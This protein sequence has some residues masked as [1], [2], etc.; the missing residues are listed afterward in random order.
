MLDQ[1]LASFVFI[2]P[3]ACLPQLPMTSKIVG[4]QPARAIPWLASIQQY[5]EHFCGGLL[6]G[7]K[8]LLTAAHCAKIVVPSIRIVVG[9]SRL[10]IEPTI[11]FEVVSI[12]RHPDY[13]NYPSQ[14]ELT[15]ND[16][17]VWELELVKGE[18]HQIPFGNI[19]FD[20]GTLTSEN[21]TLIVAGWG[22]RR[23]RGLPEMQ[24]QETQV[25]I[26]SQ[27]KCLRAYPM[28]DRNSVC[29]MS[30]GK[31]ACTGDSGGPLFEENS[32][33]KITLVGIIAF[34]FDCASNYYPGVYSRISSHLPWINSI[35]I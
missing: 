34:G 9:G 21:T 10:D 6:I 14:F 24:L 16:I 25:Q 28:L 13:K 4:G 5:N 8:T 30:P 20:D 18:V 29:A 27:S 23:R 1:L 3:T 22:A 35:K 12:T 33:G 32:N 31:D 26:I 7:N 19:V 17:A 11:E 15:K 2:S